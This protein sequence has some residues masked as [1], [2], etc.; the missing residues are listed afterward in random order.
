M[1]ERTAVAYTSVM[2]AVDWHQ[3]S[4]M[5]NNILDI[6]PDL[7][8]T[9]DRFI[10]EAMSEEEF[11]QSEDYDYYE[12]NY[13]HYLDAFEE[14]KF[15]VYQWFITDL[16]ESDARFKHE[17]FGLEYYYSEKLGCYIMPVYH[18][19]TSWRILANPIYD[20]DFAKFNQSMIRECKGGYVNI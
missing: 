16:S 13:D 4:I 14:N 9:D 6:D 15:Q 12:G 19:G 20:E 1:T 3:Q 8:W 7:L 5:C 10:D 18:L 17:V 11:E 2:D